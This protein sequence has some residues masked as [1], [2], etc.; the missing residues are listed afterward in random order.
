MI[1]KRKQP[2]N[3]EDCQPKPLG[4]ADVAANTP[5]ERTLINQIQVV[6]SRQDAAIRSIEYHIRRRGAEGAKS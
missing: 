4:L 3:G 1:W 2:C 6:R 5:K